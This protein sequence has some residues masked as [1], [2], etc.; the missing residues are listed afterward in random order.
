[1]QSLKR[2]TGGDSRERMNGRGARALKR[3]G[4]R[5]PPGRRNS[6]PPRLAQS[7][8][9]VTSSTTRASP[10]SE[11]RKARLRG[12]AREQH[13]RGPPRVSREAG[14]T[15]VEPLLT[16]PSACAALLE[17]RR[18]SSRTTTCWAHRLRR[19]CARRDPGRARG[20]S[21]QAALLKHRVPHVLCPDA[22]RHPGG[23][24]RQLAR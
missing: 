2:G 22:P 10:H 23:A 19:R 16:A 3:T 4:D 21:A 24:P 7:L 11:Q 18:E 8:Q 1:M 13:A 15:F 17:R 5:R 12:D 6:H 9:I 14:Q 20:V